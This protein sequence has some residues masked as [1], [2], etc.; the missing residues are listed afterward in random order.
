[1]SLT[2]RV[3]AITGATGVLGPIV[4][5]AFAAQGARVALLARDG[6][7]LE[8]VAATLSGVPED[9]LVVPVDLGSHDAAKQAATVV[10]DRLGST[11]ILLHLV[12]TFR[13]GS[14]LAESPAAEWDDLFEV[15]LHT[16]VR[17]MAAFLPQIQSGGWG[18]VVAVSTPFAQA[19]GGTGAAYAASK[20][21]LEALV[22]S[23][24]REAGESGVTANLVV[25][26][27]IRPRDAQSS[28]AAGKSTSPEEIAATMLWLCSDEAGTVN[29]ARIPLHG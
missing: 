25:V 7:A 17:T 8:E 11:E 1:M 5:R 6:A 23:V 12:G 24:A 18:R 9:R 2:G 28:T 10:H 29:G 22:R 4:A 14:G 19:P 15:N 3:V 21:A 20:A 27:S 26:R 16:A 13:G